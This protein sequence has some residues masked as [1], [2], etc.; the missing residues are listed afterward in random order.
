M[1]CLML[2]DQLSQYGLKESTIEKI[3]AVFAA[4]PEIE[5]VVLYGSRA[6]GSFKKGSDIDLVI[7]GE[8]VNLSQLLKLENQLDDLLLPYTIDLSL[9]HQI[10]NPELL[11]HINQVSKLL[12]EAS[13]M[14]KE[15][16]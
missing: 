5:Q 1:V 8:S 11:D 7:R 15:N 9:Q 6:Q 13:K 3:I 2:S 16:D 12:Y 4:V 10:S 14:H